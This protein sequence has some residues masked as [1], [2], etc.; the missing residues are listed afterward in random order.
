MTAV[1]SILPAQALSTIKE[2]IM[3]SRIF[4]IKYHYQCPRSVLWNKPKVKLSDVPF[5]IAI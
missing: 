3:K 4:P 2:S 5:R 1:G